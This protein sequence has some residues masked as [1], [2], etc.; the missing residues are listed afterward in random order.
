MNPAIPKE[1]RFK[2]QNTTLQYPKTMIPELFLKIP[3]LGKNF[4]IKEQREQKF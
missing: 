1:S 2:K 3:Q 4:L